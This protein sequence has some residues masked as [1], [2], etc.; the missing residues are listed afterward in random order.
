MMK[1]IGRPSLFLRHMFFNSILVFGVLFGV[2]LYF[3]HSAPT[4]A[5]FEDDLAIAASTLAVVISGRDKEA[6]EIAAYHWRTAYVNTLQPKLDAHDVQFVA[7]LGDNIVV[8]SEAAP[9]ALIETIQNNQTPTTVKDGWIIRSATIPDSTMRVGVSL[10]DGY[11]RKVIRNQV[12]VSSIRITLSYL[13]IA[14]LATLIGS[15]Y[16]LK[17]L[18]TLSNQLR[19]L[20]LSSFQILRPK[21]SFVELEPLVKAINDRT[22]ALRAQIET[23][24]TFFSNA[25]HEL[26]TPLAVIKAQAHAISNASSLEMR[27]ERIADLQ[28]GV[29]RA[30][31]ALGRILQLAR[32][33]TVLCDDESSRVNVGALIAECAAL[34]APRAYQQQQTIELTDSGDVIGRLCH[35]DLVSV[36]DNLLDNAIKYA[37]AETSITLIVGRDGDIG[38]L[39]VEDNGPGFSED[40]FTH[41][42]KRFRRGKQSDGH[43]GSGLGLAVVKAAA[44]R[45]GG[46][47][48]VA[49]P[50]AGK[51]L[52]VK[53]TFAMLS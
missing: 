47:A 2:G 24:R 46:N 31:S 35:A 15:H 38:H 50:A 44:I 14:L 42:F 10:A 12:V 20:Q 19:T 4:P 8:A 49:V 40:D 27:T 26:R 52:S 9:T 11:S 22:Q 16:A 13:F 1:F 5:Y 37:G 3:W 30:A 29:D 33:D 21:T 23:E 6:A 51:G 18:Q 17:P 34:H 25:A 41:A 39:I 53:V 36:I 45:L 43:I 48:A 28:S 7:Q 32:L